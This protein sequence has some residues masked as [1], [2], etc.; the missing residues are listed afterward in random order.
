MLVWYLIPFLFL[1]I[2]VLNQ[3]YYSDELMIYSVI[4]LVTSFLLILY[5][6]KGQLGKYGLNVYIVKF[7]RVFYFFIIFTV[8]IVLFKLLNINDENALYFGDY[9]SI[10]KEVVISSIFKPIAEELFFRGLIQSYI[11]ETLKD[12]KSLIRY[13][14]YIPIICSV[15]FFGIT[16]VQ[17]AFYMSLGSIIGL[18]VKVLFLG[19]VFAYFREKS[20]SI[21]PS[22]LAHIIHNLITV[23]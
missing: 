1:R 9:K 21:Y 16:H 19:F 13:N 2:E 18:A 17:L 23:C 22:C 7:D 14:I 3:I 5:L 15:I 12:K 8:I 11:S 6:S 10:W 4:Q 20:G